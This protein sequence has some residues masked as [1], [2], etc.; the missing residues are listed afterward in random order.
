MTNKLTPADL[1]KLDELEQQF[2]QAVKDHPANFRVAFA[3]AQH[4]YHRL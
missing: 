2:V 3:L 1:D 4:V